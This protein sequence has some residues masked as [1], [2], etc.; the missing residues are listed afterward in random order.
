VGNDTGPIHVIAASGCPTVVLFSAESHPVK[1]KPQGPSVEVL[2]RP[3]LAHLTVAEV[4]S[5]VKGL[6]R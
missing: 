4:M 6:A 5:A 3:V 1:S 2:H